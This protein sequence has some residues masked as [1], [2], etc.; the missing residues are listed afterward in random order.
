MVQPLIEEP[1][2][3]LTEAGRAAFEGIISQI[4]NAC[5]VCPN[6]CDNLILESDA[7][8]FVPTAKK[9]KVRNLNDVENPA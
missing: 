5:I 8:E 9:G 1:S 3:P 2:F 4:A 7:S 6:D